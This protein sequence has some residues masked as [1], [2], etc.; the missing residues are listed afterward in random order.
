MS[1]LISSMFHLAVRLA[2]HPFVTYT[3][4]IKLPQRASFDHYVARNLRGSFITSWIEHSFFS[5][6][7]EASNAEIRFRSMVLPQFSFRERGLASVCGCAPSPQHYSKTV[8]SIGNHSWQFIAV[9]L[10]FNI[11]TQILT[12]VWPEQIGQPLL[13]V[14]VTFYLQAFSLLLPTVTYT[15]LLSRSS[16][17]TIALA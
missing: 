5:A 2:R 6:R 17:S 15:S 10:D 14:V 8:S 1:W 11:K 4:N 16:L 13:F 7:Y 9:S 3:L 12:K